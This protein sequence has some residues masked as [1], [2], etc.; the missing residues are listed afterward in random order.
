MI[1]DLLKL[2]I[3]GLTGGLIDFDEKPRPS[4]P[5][6]NRRKQQMERELVEALSIIRQVAQE[7]E[8]MRAEIEQLKSGETKK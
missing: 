6:N 3:G 5:Q 7:R 1:G 2:T 8:S 4:R